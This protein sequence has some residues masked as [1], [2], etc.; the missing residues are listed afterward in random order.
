MVVKLKGL[1][2]KD[3]SK[4]EEVRGGY[5]V[6]LSFES[7]KVLGQVDF[8]DLKEEDLQVIQQVSGI[9]APHLESIVDGFYSKLLGIPILSS[10]IHENSSPGR[11][12]ETLLRHIAEMM[13]GKFDEAFIQQRMTI[14]RVHYQ[15]GLE[16]Q[17]YMGAFQLLQDGIIRFVE[18][19]VSDRDVVVRFNRAIVKVFNFEQQLVLEEYHRSYIDGISR[20]NRK[21]RDEVKE[22]IGATSGNLVTISETAQQLMRMLAVKGNDV[23]STVQKTAER[24]VMTQTMAQSGYEQME[25][26][27]EKIMQIKTGSIEMRRMVEHVSTSSWEILEVINIVKTIADQTNLLALNSSIEAARAGV[28]GK[29]FAV[30]AQEIKKLA[31]ETK[32][33]IYR[34]TELVK[35]N[36][37]FID[38]TVH[39]LSTVGERIEEGSRDF[40]QTRTSFEGIVEAMDENIQY[41]EQAVEGIKSLIEGITD[42]GARTEDI[43]VAMEELNET[44][45]RL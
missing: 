30:V 29:G 3:N 15:I 11:L 5:S 22:S 43:V 38:E 35:M 10:I 36:H 33:S 23:A 45:N 42:T 34:I 17:W 7:K 32:D 28:H 9:I 21:V 6:M 4:V 25:L 13:E 14:A 41:V 16:P 40:E 37:K 20:E 1:F 26:L 44:A 27:N 39:T 8:I 19:N 12:R 24:S 18:E 2:Q 31:D